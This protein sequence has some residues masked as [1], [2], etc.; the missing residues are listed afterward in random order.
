MSYQDIFSCCIIIATIMIC[1]SQWFGNPLQIKI[2]TFISGVLWI[3]YTTHIGLYLDSL[4]IFIECII[5][6]GSIISIIR[7]KKFKK[8]ESNLFTK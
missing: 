4:K 6:V 2:C 8:L 3:I 1:I 5:L 7:S